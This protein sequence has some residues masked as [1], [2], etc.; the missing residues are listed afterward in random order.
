QA[1][2]GRAAVAI[3]RAA[4]A[5]EPLV[6]AA[7][8]LTDRA[9]VDVARL[10]AAAYD[11]CAGDTSTECDRI[12]ATADEAQRDMRRLRAG[13]LDLEC[14]LRAVATPT[15]DLDT[16]A[17]RLVASATAIEKV[18]AAATR[19]ADD[20]AARTAD[21]DRRLIAFCEDA[22]LPCPPSLLED[23]QRVRTLTA[24]IAA[25]Q[26]S[27]NRAVAALTGQAATAAAQI[28]RLPALIATGMAQVRLLAAGADQVASGADQLSSG[29]DE[30]ADGSGE[31][32]TGLKQLVTGAQTLASGLADGAAQIPQLDEATR[33]S[34]AAVLGSPVDL[35]TVNLN[36]ASL[37]GR[38]LAPFFFGIALWVF[39]LIAYQLMRPVNPTALAGITAAPTV[40]LG[41]WL[42]AA[43]LGI[44]GAG[45]LYGVT[46]IGLG[47]SPRSAAGTLGLMILGVCAFLAIA[48]LLKLAF[49][50]VGELLTLVLLML[51]LTSAGGLY[52]VPTTPAPFQALHPLL[53]MTYLVDGLRITISGGQG[54]HL[55]RDVLVLTGYLVGALLLAVLVVAR[56]RRW[57]FGRLHPAV[58]M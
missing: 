2:L 49:G 25:A 41:G 20:L 17:A 11:V 58:E 10:R 53:P 42:P 26:R 13:L 22:P 33:T 48:H 27:T 52:P 9:A 55:A 15:D 30:A 19:T 5:V 14:E 4:Q 16:V 29:I 8:H 31:L 37:Y 23:A 47:L 44:A 51:Q 3:A 54:A 12:R 21:V 46:D 39:G 45:V 1:E 32:V 7:V 35:T 18:S 40:A 56:Q 43:G 38:G 24:D 6:R 28:R 50:V 34:T 36:P 57:S